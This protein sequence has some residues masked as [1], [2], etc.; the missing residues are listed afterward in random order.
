MP[1]IPGALPVEL[2]PDL[3]TAL[4]EELGAISSSI[5][6]IENELVVGLE[7]ETTS[8]RQAAEAAASAGTDAQEETVTLGEA[9]ATLRE[10]ATALEEKDTELEAADAEL[11]AEDTELEM[12]IS[13]LMTRL[14][15]LTSRVQALE[16]A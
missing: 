8:V 14:S 11:M 1:Y 12:S 10:R 16:D 13:T 7:S 4:Q 5:Q 6:I 9:I 3:I 2:S 15:E